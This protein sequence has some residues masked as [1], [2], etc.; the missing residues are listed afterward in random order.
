ME[1]KNDMQA[2]EKVPVGKKYIVNG[3]VYGAGATPITA[4]AVNHSQV[5]APTIKKEVLDEL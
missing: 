2:G 4:S 5:S 1:I 3:R